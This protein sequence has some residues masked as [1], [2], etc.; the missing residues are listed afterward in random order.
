MSDQSYEIPTG[1]RVTISENLE[2]EIRS[3]FEKDRENKFQL[4][5]LSSGIR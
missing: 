2:D 1:K 5:L 3:R 4:F